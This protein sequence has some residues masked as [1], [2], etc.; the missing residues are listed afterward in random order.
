[1]GGVRLFKHQARLGAKTVS[2]KMQH[3]QIHSFILTHLLLIVQDSL[4]RVLGCYAAAHLNEGQGSDHEGIVDRLGLIHLNMRCA[5][6][7][8]QDDPAVAAEYCAIQNCIPDNFLA[9]FLV[10]KQLP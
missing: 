4:G 6:I 7:D 5:G 10:S 9:V 2:A 8:L 3:V 1:M